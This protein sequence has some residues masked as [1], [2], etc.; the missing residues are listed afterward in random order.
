VTD[1]IQANAFTKHYPVGFWRKRS[2]V[3]L[4]ALT[5]AVHQGEVFGFLGPNGVGETTML[6]L[7][8]Q[9]IPAD[10]PFSLESGVIELSSELPLSPLPIQ[11]P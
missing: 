6:E 8:M 7:F 2:Y 5:I 4:D 1:A 11:S 3:A 9:L 10:I